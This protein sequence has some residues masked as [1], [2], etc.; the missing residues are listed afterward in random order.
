MKIIRNGREYPKQITCEKC[1][2]IIE[3][4]K[5]DEEEMNHNSFD[6][7]PIFILMKNVIKDYPKYIRCPVCGTF[8]PTSVEYKNEMFNE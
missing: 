8:M 5:E 6:S 4:E 2:S 3:Y 1:N 7:N